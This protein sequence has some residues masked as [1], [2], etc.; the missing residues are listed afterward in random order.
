MNF[1]KKA[2]FTALTL[3]MVSG[4]AFA[5][6]PEIPDEHI[7]NITPG[8][9]E[10]ISILCV[11]NSILN[12][13]PSADIG[14]SGSWGMAASS[15]DKD[16]Y[17]LLQ[18][19]VKEAGYTNVAWSSTGVATL[20]R[21]IDKR[22]DYDYKA[23]IDQLLAP[24]VRAAMPDIVIFQIGENVNQGPTRESY[25]IALE[26]LAEFCVSVNPDVE[27]IFCMPFWG[28]DAKCLGVKDAA[29]ETG[30]TYADL[31]QFN[32]D[33]NKAI[34]LFEH[35]GVAIHPGD[36]GMA[37]IADEIF[38]QLEVVLYKKYVDPNQVE[39]KLDGKYVYFDVPAQIIDSRT[40]IPIRA[41][42]E[43]FSADVGWDGETETV[44]IIRPG[45]EI[46]M[47]LGENFFT[48]NG[49]KFDLDVP[50]LETGGRTLVP[51]RA[52]A[53]AFDCKVDWDEAAWTAI[54]TSPEKTPAVLTGID[55]KCNSLNA[56]GFY[57]SSSKLTIVDE[58]EEQGKAIYVEATTSAKSW[59]YI[60]AK[61]AIQSG[62]TYV[63]EAD[64]KALDTDGAGNTVDE[65]G[66]GFCMRH[67][68]KDHAVKVTQVK[69]S[70]GWVHVTA[71][72]AVPGDMVPNPDDDRFGIYANPINDIAA[73]FAIDNVVVKIKE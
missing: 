16:Y 31:S 38:K 72:Y 26:K 45:E 22:T 20:E 5:A 35:S 1:L 67:D 36:Q 63:I 53:E 12:H 41:V 7:T 11:G 13:G 65:V 28:G 19:K 39:V 8:S 21:A 37:N 27:I 50:A 23:E 3:G 32:T 42:A 24:S 73:S 55:D 10:Q 14:W 40:M 6:E 18:D 68:G 43:A 70:D 47:K 49:E 17:H 9:E 48:K 34:G 33:E 30:F 69:V 51:A 44:T 4:M 59:T 61:F 25:K 57:G 58:N 15:A 60:W 52:I 64:L 29:I 2:V 46:V 54:I 66:I 71:E 56:S 62:K